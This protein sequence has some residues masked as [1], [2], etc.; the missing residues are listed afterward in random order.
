VLELFRIE[1][2]AIA[3]VEGVTSFQP[4]LMPTQWLRQ[5]AP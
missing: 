5:D 1:D 3:R 4:Y 2:G